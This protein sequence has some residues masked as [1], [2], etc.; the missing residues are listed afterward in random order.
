MTSWKRKN[1]ESHK[2]QIFISC[3]TK[4]ERTKD[5]DIKDIHRN[6]YQSEIADEQQLEEKAEM[7]NE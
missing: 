1:K 3:C 2:A 4:T 7:L 6:I 5:S